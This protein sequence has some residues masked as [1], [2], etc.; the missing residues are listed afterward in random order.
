MVSKEPDSKDFDWTMVE[1]AVETEL[2]DRATRVPQ[3]IADRVRWVTEDAGRA[4]RLGPDDPTEVCAT[5]L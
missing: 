1:R 5:V 4:C 3:G 2:L